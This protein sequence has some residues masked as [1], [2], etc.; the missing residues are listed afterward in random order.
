MERIL[1][2]LIIGL[3]SQ[4]VWPTLPPAWIGYCLLLVVLT[5]LSKAPFICGCVLGTSLSI[6][7]INHQF[8]DLSY[9]LSSNS[10]IKGT[11]VSLPKQGKFGTRF[12]LKLSYIK[13]ANDQIRSSATVSV[14]WPGKHDVE[15]GQQLRFTVKGRPLHSLMNDGGFNY[16]RWL[17]SQGV[18]VELIVISG[19]TIDDS[20]SYRQH[21]RQ[22][23]A[24]VTQGLST[25]RFMMA[26][27]IGDKSLFNDDDW[28]VLKRS[29]TGHLFS[30]SGLHL[31]LVAAGCF[32]VISRLLN[33]C[34]RG[35]TR[36]YLPHI[37]GFLCLIAATFYAYLSGFNLPAQRALSILVVLF[38]FSLLGQRIS[39]ACKL[40]GCLTIVLII[41]PVAVL[42]MS[43]WLS[44]AA[45]AIIYVLVS[46][47]RP[48][49]RN[50]FD[51]K[52]TFSRLREILVYWISSFIR[53]QVWLSLGLMLINMHFFNGLSTIGPLA[54]LVAVPI[55]S[56]LILPL[57]FL[58]VVGLVFSP[59]NTVSDSCFY[60]ADWLL[61]WLMYFIERLSTLSFG[62]VDMPQPSVFWCI[63]LAFV[64]YLLYWSCRS[65][66]WL[67]KSIKTRL[68]MLCC[69]I[70]LFV[71]TVQHGASDLSRW[72]IVFLDVGQ[73][74]AAVIIR[75]DRGIII[76]TG[77]DYGNGTSAAQRVILPF[78]AYRGINSIDY[79]IATHDDND[80]SGGVAL[81]SNV[82]KNAE[83]IGNQTIIDGVSAKDC[84]NLR[85]IKW[86]G[87]TLKF[88]RAPGSIAQ[89]NNDKSCLIHIGDGIK[90]ALFTGDIQKRAERH[91]T[92]VLDQSWYANV[93]QIA[94]HG[95]KTSSSGEFLDVIS[96]QF[97]VISSSRF[98]QWRFPNSQVIKRL[99]QRGI[100]YHVTA[101]EGQ[102]TIEFGENGGLLTSYRRNSAP[103]WYNRDLSFGHYR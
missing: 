9:L 103:F 21:L 73:G 76:D 86:Q 20:S 6:L 82:F 74:N 77:N 67:I 54:N 50:Q 72:Q 3:I 91:L 96:P 84:K 30:I 34:Y 18:S 19:K 4:L 51:D 44:F 71:A 89:S 16:Q 35:S 11:I 102:I 33:F 31:S 7:L 17:V 100:E 78:L 62:W 101:V 15:V 59:N 70:F 65:G 69:S 32:V 83:I 75:N 13:T 24:D 60:I 55:V 37:T 93:I 39:L 36:H 28:Q 38:L 63:S 26:L 53:L 97:A 8:N 92:N 14:F 22:R 56:I 49:N 42:S 29:A 5:L 46:V 12:N 64:A 95:S 88:T 58:G 61:N 43:F 45:V 47:Q 27:G 41:S 40:L 1:G 81:L 99:K 85:P 66:Y 57:V 90:S 80:H 94:H 2:G 79:I 87:L 48:T 25:H 10:S 52:R 98:N 23:L 68:V